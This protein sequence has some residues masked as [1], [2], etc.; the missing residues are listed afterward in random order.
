MAYG[1]P[2][3]FINKKISERNRTMK[4]YFV[5]TLVLVLVLTSFSGFAYNGVSEWAT[6][7]I[8]FARSNGLI[9]QSFQDKEFV[10]EISREGFAELCVSLYEGVTGKKAVMPE[11]NPFTDTDNTTV[12]KAYELGVINGVN[13][14]MFDPFANVTREQAAAMM[15][16]T[17]VKTGEEINSDSVVSFSDD[18][19]IS[20]WAKESV[21]KMSSAGIIKGKDGGRFA[22]IDGITVEEAVVISVRLYN[23]LTAVETEEPTEE[24]NLADSAPVI[25]FGEEPIIE[26]TERAVNITVNGATLEDYNQY[27]IDVQGY[28]FNDVENI[29]PDTFIIANNGKVRINVSYGNSVMK[30]ELTKIN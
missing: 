11:I 28:G 6:V 29:L 15:E 2:T 12:T 10:R 24:V 3:T 26:E 1:S 16:R 7:E 30:I 27:I 14:Y 20:E 19:E 18:G 23:E 8:E 13:E 17:A 9:P 21:Y 22:P 4:K 5:S 25:S